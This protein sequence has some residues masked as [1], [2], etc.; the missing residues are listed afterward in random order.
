MAQEQEIGT[1]M[2]PAVPEQQQPQNE[3][4]SGSAVAAA[5]IVT[6]IAMASAPGPLAA[7][8]Q[9]SGQVVPVPSQQ[10]LPP[11]EVAVA[12]AIAG[13][14]RGEK[15]QLPPDTT[16]WTTVVGADTIALNPYIGNPAAFIEWL[17]VNGLM[18]QSQTPE[19]YAEQQQ[20]QQEQLHLA[21][22]FLQQ[23]MGVPTPEPAIP[24]VHGP[25]PAGLAPSAGSFGQQPVIQPPADYSRVYS[26][27]CSVI[28]SGQGP[29]AQIERL[30]DLPAAERDLALLLLHQMSISL[31]AAQLQ[32][33]FAAHLSLYRSSLISHQ[34][35]SSS[36][37]Q[38]QQPVDPLVSVLEAAPQ[39]EEPP[40]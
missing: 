39:P 31:A 10:Q 13:E 18:P 29:E 15:R 12:S 26:F 6:G 22:I 4:V 20:R 7:E 5:P 33:Q 24:D 14:E 21:Q 16:P 35:A 40:K 37:S 17:V 3:G 38:H 8:Q 28:E 25:R 36:Q 30:R 1:A 27:L 23:A 2:M 9:A 11:I 34:A 32:E 19:Q